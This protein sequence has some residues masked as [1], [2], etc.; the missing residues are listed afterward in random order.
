M[1]IF[2]KRIVKKNIFSNNKLLVIIKSIIIWLNNIY[3][4]TISINL[5][6]IKFNSIKIK[7]I[8]ISEVIHKIIQNI[9]QTNVKHF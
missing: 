3:K 8:L 4:I 1:I 9:Y 2:Y 5:N 6:R 7:C